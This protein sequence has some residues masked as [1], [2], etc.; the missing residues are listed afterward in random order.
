MPIYAFRCDQCNH[1]F[2]E[3]TS[4]SGQ[5]KVVCPKCQGKVDRVYEGKCAFG[6]KSTQGGKGCSGSCSDCAGCGGH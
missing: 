6:A 1:K 4:I 5:D 3:L 2:D